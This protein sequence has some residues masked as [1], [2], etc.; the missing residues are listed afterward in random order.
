MHHYEIHV[1]VKGADPL[2]F[3]EVCKA[4]GVK[5]VLLHLQLTGENTVDD[6]MTSS[7]YSGT[8]AG[9]ILEV[10]RIEDYLVGCG[11][12]V[13][14]RKIETYPDHP[15]A[16]LFP[17]AKENYFECHLGVTC[18]EDQI[19]ILKEI[20]GYY[21]AHLSR[22]VFKMNPDG[23][24]VV[25]MTLRRRDLNKMHFNILRDLLASELFDVHKFHIGKLETEFVWFDDNEEHDR[26]WI[27]S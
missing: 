3:Q 23:S 8:D 14:R 22:N 24:Q 25:M 19:P 15:R 17:L 20:A 5:P 21:G 11:L 9:C 16:K 18:K 2:Y 6:M 10:W 4:V 27:E 7:R 26:R 13:V 12:D 1:T